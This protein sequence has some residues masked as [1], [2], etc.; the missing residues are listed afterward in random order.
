VAKALTPYQGPAHGVVD[1]RIADVEAVARWF[2]YIFVLPGGF[3]FGM[4]GI[5]GLIPGIGDVFD[6]LVSLYIVY[7]AI[8]LGVARVTIAR[9]MV[10]VG[11]EGIAG[12]LPFIGDFFDVV[13]K[14]NLRN[15]QI[16]KSHLAQ[17]R[18]QSRLDWLFL[19][20]TALLVVIAVALPVIVLAAL[21]RR[22]A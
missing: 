9:M 16:L 1:P 8:Q 2:D 21:I 13:F 19:M 4:A 22:F 5:I 12:S 7:R 14:A 17:P 10:N 15:Y 6:G 3:R 20:G 11:I 18:R